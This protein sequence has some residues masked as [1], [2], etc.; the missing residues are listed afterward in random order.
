M[1][2]LL[3]PMVHEGFLCLEE[4]MIH[5]ESLIDIMF[6]L[7]FGWPP[8]TGGPMKW[9]RNRSLQR[10]A[11]KVKHWNNIEPTD[12]TYK[13]SALLVKEAADIAKL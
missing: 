12:R 10:V 7:G 3:Y 1:E 13:L 4:E 6:I 9:G 2:F 8:A 11:E 5:E